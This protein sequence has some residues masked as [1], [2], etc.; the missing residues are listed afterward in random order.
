MAFFI[1]KTIWSN[2]ELI[3]INICSIAFGIILG[4]YYT[5][6]LKAYLY[7]VWIVF[8]VVAIWGLIVW[9]R[10]MKV[11]KNTKSW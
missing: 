8:G 9:L 3:I 1:I 2:I 5:E 6:F 11:A 4:I 10:K 7:L